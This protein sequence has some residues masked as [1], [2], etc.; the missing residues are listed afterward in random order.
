LVNARTNPKWNYKWNGHCVKST[1][2]W[3][4][5]VMILDTAKKP[6][7]KN[8]KDSDEA[9][10]LTKTATAENGKKGGVFERKDGED[11][12]NND[13]TTL[14]DEIKTSVSI[15]DQDAT[16]EPSSFD[17]T[18]DMT[19]LAATGLSVDDK[20]TPSS[21]LLQFGYLTIGACAT[22]VML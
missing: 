8:S 1:L 10:T 2:E 17:T 6:G 14:D 5:P 16:L 11:N 21:S 18:H 7:N 13:E 12:G 19:A 15:D 3:T 4:S 22:I 9:I 20:D